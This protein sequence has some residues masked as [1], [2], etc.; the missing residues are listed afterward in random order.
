MRMIAL[1]ELER[2]HETINT[3]SAG[4]KRSQTIARLQTSALRGAD[5]AVALARKV[6]STAFLASALHTLAQV[7]N[8]CGYG[9]RASDLAHEAES[10]FKEVAD[11]GGEAN[12]LVV[13]ADACVVK[14]DRQAATELVNQA[15]AIFSS[16]GDADGEALARSVLGA[17]GQQALAAP[18]PGEGDA[19]EM[20][21]ASAP[22]KMSMDFEVAK[23]MARESAL[24]ALGTDEDEVEMD[25]PLMDMGLDSLSAISFREALVQTSG[26]KLP[27]SLVFDY[28]SLQAIAQFMVEE[29]AN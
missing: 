19:G 24:Q 11:Q 20:S 29:S 10:L 27:A 28:P 3:A 16:L 9:E 13:A 7:N 2:L 21:A 4:P 22:A 14:G 12:A 6:E 15:A 5:K 25:S 23:T 18:E 1:M 17:R 8:A 26:L